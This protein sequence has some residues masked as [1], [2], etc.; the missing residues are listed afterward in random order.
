MFKTHPQSTPNAI[1]KLF[2]R[3]KIRY[4]YGLRD[5]ELLVTSNMKMFNFKYHGNSLLNTILK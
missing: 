2:I 3:N 4:N 1:N 5:K